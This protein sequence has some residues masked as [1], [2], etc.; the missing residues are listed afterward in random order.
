VAATALTFTLLSALW[1]PQHQ[2]LRS[3]QPC[4]CHSINLNERIGMTGVIYV[5]LNERT[6]MNEAVYVNLDERISPVAAIS[7]RQ[8]GHTPAIQV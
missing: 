1:S 6:G 3:C 4:G 8:A 5:N 7:I 2:P